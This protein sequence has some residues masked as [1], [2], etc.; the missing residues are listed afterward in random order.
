MVVYI[1]GSLRNPLIPE[2]AN[3]IQAA[4][5]EAFADWYGA[6]YEADDKWKE[7]NEARGRSYLDALHSH[8]ARA[9]FEF[10][11]KHLERADAVILIAPAGKSGHMELG[12]ALGKGKLGYYLLD[13]PD[14][15]DVMLSFATL[16][17]DKLDE[18]LKH[19]ESQ[20][21]QQQAFDWGV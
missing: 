8:G 3:K 4:G 15:W 6:G 20:E 18:I 17:T 13:N 10:D 12:W 16:V 11:K 5:H 9:V 7:Y 19:I 14:R 21:P 1:I 2:I